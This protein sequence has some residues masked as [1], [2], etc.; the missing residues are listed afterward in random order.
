[1]PSLS[2]VFV[3]IYPNYSKIRNLFLLNG[4]ASSTLMQE[5]IPD[6]MQMSTEFF[7]ALC[8]AVFGFWCSLK[9]SNWVLVK[10]SEIA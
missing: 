3:D 6:S 5:S 1:M 7:L 2:K 9:G 4:S 8:Y 10:P